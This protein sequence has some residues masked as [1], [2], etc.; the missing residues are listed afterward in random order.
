VATPLPDLFTQAQLEQAVGGPDKLRQ[1]GD[2][3]R[4]GVLD[5]DWY[6]EV[7]RA[8]NGEVYSYLGVDLNVTD[9]NLA[10]AGVLQE[11]ALDV[12]AFWAY[13]KG[14]GGQAI[15]EKIG[16][17]Y[18]LAIASLK[19]FRAGERRVDLVE[20]PARAAPAAAVNMDPDNHSGWTRRRW[21]GFC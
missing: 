15:P 20:E 3:D 8:A 19:E 9:P 1:L 14:T 4:D 7:K 21:S 5:A 10:A 17:A 18:T 16:D 2:R 13:K 6:A 11:Y 12:A